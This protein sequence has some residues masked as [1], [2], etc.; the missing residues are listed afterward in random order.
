VNGNGAVQDD[1]GRKRMLDAREALVRQT[2]D[3]EMSVLR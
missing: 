3:R 2:L 1:E